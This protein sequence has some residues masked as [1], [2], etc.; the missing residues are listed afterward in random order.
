MKAPG[1]MKMRVS[2]HPLERKKETPPP[3]SRG[4][5]PTVVGGAGPPADP[6]AT[7]FD[8]ESAPVFLVSSNQINRLQ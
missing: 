6:P 7:T 4:A 5:R 1:P 8:R 3:H 2:C